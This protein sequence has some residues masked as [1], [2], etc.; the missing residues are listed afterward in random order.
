MS[1][2]EG[3]YIGLS[4]SSTPEFWFLPYPAPSSKLR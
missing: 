4:P 3:V 2:S 1:S